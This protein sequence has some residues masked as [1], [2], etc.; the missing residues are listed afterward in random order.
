MSGGAAHVVAVSGNPRAGSRTAA[1]A[2]AAAD[3]V[4]DALEGEATVELL[5]LAAP[6]L[7]PDAARATL[8][9]ST[10]A[11][12]ASPT[13][14]ATYTGLLKSLLDG[15]GPNALDGVVAVPLM[16]FAGAQHAL[17]ADL[18]LRP[19]LLELGATTPT[20]AIAAPDAEIAEPEELLD[21]WLARSGWALRA[22]ASAALARRA[23]RVAA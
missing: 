8:A 5:D 14:K 12:V 11:I 17:A 10:V 22:T 2:R 19:L 9:A 7:D 21:A 1:F 16:V 3:A 6:G 4:A 18:H 15:Y 13:Y 23:V 20:A